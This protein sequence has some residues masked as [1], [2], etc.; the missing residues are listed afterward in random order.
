MTKAPAYIAE[1]IEMPGFP[2]MSITRADCHA[3]FIEAGATPAD[4]DRYA[5]GW[6]RRSDIS[7]EPHA[8]A[9]LVH[10]LNGNSPATFAA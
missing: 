8:K 2:A 9:L 7:A 3:A 10:T 5:F 4:A 6:A 1:V